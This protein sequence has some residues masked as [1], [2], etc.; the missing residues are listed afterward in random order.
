MFHWR[1]APAEDNRFS[2]DFCA[3]PEEC[4]CRVCWL[5]WKSWVTTERYNSLYQE[6]LKAKEDRKKL[7]KKLWR[8]VKKG[9]RFTHRR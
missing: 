2:F 5:S 3:E 6:R 4:N 8:G 9:R 7:R 1:S